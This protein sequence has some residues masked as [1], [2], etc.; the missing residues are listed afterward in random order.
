MESIGLWWSDRPYR[1]YL[2]RPIHPT[3]PR[4]LP[5]P[6][7]VHSTPPHTDHRTAPESRCRRPTHQARGH[8]HRAVL[9]S[10]SSTPDRRQYGPETHSHPARSPSRIV[11]RQ[12]H[13]HLCQLECG[14][15]RVV[16]EMVQEPTRDLE[17]DKTPPS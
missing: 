17:A 11:L 6:S 5:T 4:A 1:S 8:H 10:Q 16:L 14:H 2:I 13:K 3:L 15:R 7:Q 9:Q 12:T